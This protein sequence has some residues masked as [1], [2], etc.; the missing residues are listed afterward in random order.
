MARISKRGG[1]T[2]PTLPL[3]NIV[4]LMLIFFLVSAQLARPIDPNLQ[5]AETD[6]PELIPP[7]DAVILSRDGTVTFRGEQLANE[8]IVAALKSEAGQ[9]D[10]KLRILPDRRSDASDLTTLAAEFRKLGATSISIVTQR[11]LE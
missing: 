3:I 8:A 9:D 10:L 4:F 2:E 5:L 1:Q 6:H 7:P 11:G